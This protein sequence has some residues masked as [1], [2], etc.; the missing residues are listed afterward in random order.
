LPHALIS[1]TE[2]IVA[3]PFAADALAAHLPRAEVAHIAEAGHSAYFE[4]APRF[5]ARV[6]QFLAGC[7]WAPL[8]REF[9][10]ENNP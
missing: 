9:S 8:G 7:G 5:N 4:R 1:G 2:D 10:V 3:P 6:A